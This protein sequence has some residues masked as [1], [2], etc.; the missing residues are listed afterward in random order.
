MPSWTSALTSACATREPKTC[1]AGA[2]DSMILLRPPASTVP[3]ASVTTAPTG[4]VPAPN[5]S[6]ASRDASRQAGSRSSQPC[7]GES[8]ELSRRCEAVERS[9]R[10]D[11]REEVRHEVLER[12]G[13]LEPADGDRVVARIAD[14]LLRHVAGLRIR[15][16]ET[17]WAR[18]LCV[19]LVVERREVG[20]DRFRDGT[21]RMRLHLVRKR[22]VLLVAASKRVRCVDRDLALDTVHVA[23]R[24]GDR[25]RRNGDQDDV[26]V[27]G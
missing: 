17:A 20:V 11:L 1:P 5:A 2:D 24:R 22:L 10:L 18:P 23:E 4:I 12:A 14:E 6:H 26:C 7:T 16:E 21:V 13:V 3:S 8:L 25:S 9:A 15:G 27:A 19:D